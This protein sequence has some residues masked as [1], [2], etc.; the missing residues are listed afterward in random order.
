M[1][2][3]L[4][5]ARDAPHMR[6][7]PQR[8]CIVTREPAKP[9]DLIRF[10]RAPDGAVVPDLGNRLPGRGAWV[11]NSR[12]KLETAVR[13]R[14]F[15]RAFKADAAADPDL[16]ERVDRLLAERV[17]GLL[18]LARK[19]GE[20]ITGFD[21]VDK[22]ARRRLLAVVFHAADGAEDGLRKITGALAA[23]GQR[24]TVLMVREFTSK[25][26]NLA[27]GLANV[28]HAAVPAGPMGRAL[29]ER[30]TRLVQYR[31][32]GCAKS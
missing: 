16:P 14:L 12:A 25:E 9:E 2:A 4:A 28:I 3:D 27:L 6:S 13:K 26:L 17:L 5:Q 23:G 7:G 18:G 32:G 1:M 24:D 30:A 29:A 31:G 20:V 21:Q 22:A 8:S 10:V 11:G 15:A 19:A